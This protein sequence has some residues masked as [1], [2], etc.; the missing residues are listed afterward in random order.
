MG[1]LATFFKIG[2]FAFGGGFTT[3]PLI[4]HMVV[5]GMHWLD[6]S[7]F[8]DGIAM[9]QITPGPVFITATFI[10]YKV[11]GIAG[12][13][14][15]TIAI[16]APSLAAIMLVGPAHARIKNLKI[17]KVV[18][19]GFL[20]G[21]IGLLLSVVLQFGIQSLVNVQTWAIW[22]LPRSPLAMVE[23]GY[24]LADPW[25]NRCLIGPVLKF[26]GHSSPNLSLWFSAWKDKTGLRDFLPFPE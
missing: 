25:N 21:F 3:I 13:L 16:F 19:K 1:D 10:G 18:I 8:R 9:G 12:A 22:R 5:D 2:I 15:A 17:I 24:S 7:A 4:Q 14:V 11:R 26:L 23:E 20:S 6:L